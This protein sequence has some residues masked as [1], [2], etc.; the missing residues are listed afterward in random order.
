M[1]QQIGAA[2]SIAR[3]AF[4]QRMAV[5]E[6][7][8]QEEN[9]RLAALKK[10]IQEDQ[11][12]SYVEQQNA[13]RAGMK[14]QMDAVLTE[15]KQRQA[16]LADIGAREKERLDAINAEPR[17]D[18]L[19]QTLALHSLFEAKDSRGN[20]AFW[21]YGILTLLFMLVDTIP[22]L[23]KFFCRPGPYDSLVDRDE[24]KFEAEHR[25]FQDYHRHY[26]NQ[27]RT[28]KLLVSTRSRTLEAALTDGVEQTKA[29]QAFL[30]SLMEMEADFHRKLS[31]ERDKSDNSTPE[32][33]QLL[34]TM[35]E[36]FY[37]SLKTRMEHY[38]AKAAVA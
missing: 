23:V 3:D 5:A 29:A 16:D 19:T 33:E 6:S 8:A 14:Q 30:D 10:K 25:A 9:I 21:T 27:V 28:G 2:E 17:R 22:L 12:A 37:A 13:L 34:E 20:F 35:K 36:Q 32:K 1:E 24:M 11:A 15:M 18:I 26:L 7:K 4:Q 38:F 31:A